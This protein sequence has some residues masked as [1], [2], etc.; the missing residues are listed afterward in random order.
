MISLKNQQKGWVSVGR[1]LDYQKSYVLREIT[2]TSPVTKNYYTLSFTID[3]EWDHDVVYIALNYPYTFT[4]MVGFLQNVQERSRGQ[5][6]LVQREIIGYSLSNNPIVAVKIRH[7]GNNGGR[8]VVVMG[9]QHPG[10]TVSS[11]T[12]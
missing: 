10:Q 9:R 12:I 2:S 3:F 5:N 6:V 4:K 7:K 1:D 11:Y 8:K